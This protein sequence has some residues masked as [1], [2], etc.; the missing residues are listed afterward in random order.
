M[1]TEQ[2]REEFE[3]WLISTGESAD[4]QNRIY[5]SPI[6]NISWNAWQ[7]SRASLSVELPKP[8]AYLI[9][10]QAGRG[11]DDYWDDVEVSHSKEDKCCDGSD[12]YRVYSEFEV[13][14]MLRAAGI[15]VKEG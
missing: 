14:E 11:P 10:I 12:R 1:S 7:A 8:H 5:L 15:T 9:W 6:A 4:S 2:L 3:R 13:S